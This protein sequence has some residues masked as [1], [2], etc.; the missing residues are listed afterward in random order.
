MAIEVLAMNISKSENQI[1]YIGGLPRGGLIP[2]VLLS[3]KLNIPFISSINF[4]RTPGNILVI[5][6]ICD[7]GKTLNPFRYE[8]NIY[9]AT[10][11]YKQSASLEPDFWWRL[12]GEDE[13][14]YYP[15]ER[16]DSIPIADYLKKKIE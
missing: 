2:A 10:L 12:V 14:I 3:H 9:T 13:Y 7:T 15:W 5:D 11:H 8:E 4:L 16:K 1:N 6:D